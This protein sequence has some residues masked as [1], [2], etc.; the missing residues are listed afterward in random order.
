M[1][2]HLRQQEAMAGPTWLMSSGDAG[3]QGAGVYLGLP[4]SQWHWL[5]R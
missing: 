5:P 1:I 2:Q 3:V 4:G